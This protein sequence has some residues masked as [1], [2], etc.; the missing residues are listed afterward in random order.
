MSKL[1]NYGLGYYGCAGQSPE[2]SPNYGLS[3]IA[4]NL[5]NRG[6]TGNYMNLTKPQQLQAI[7]NM[8]MQRKM[9]LSRDMQDS[10]MQDVQNKKPYEISLPP[11]AVG[12]L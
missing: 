10:S 4:Y 8:N 11:N 12:V 7:K 5:A 9:Q 1:F 2:N 6:L 3:T